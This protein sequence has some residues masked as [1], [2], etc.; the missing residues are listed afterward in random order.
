MPIAP[1]LDEALETPRLQALERMRLLDTPP[2]ESID[3]IIQLASQL[4]NVPIVLV[5]LVDKDRV[6]FKARHGIGV[7]EV[8]RAASICNQAILQDDVFV[9]PDALADPRF[10]DCPLVTGEPYVRFFAGCPLKAFSNHNIGTLCLIDLQ[11]RRFSGE[12]RELL[13]T[14]AQ[15]AQS[16]L[17]ELTRAIVDELTQVT[18]RGGFRQL[19]AQALAA[20]SQADRDSVLLVLNLNTLAMIKDHYGHE[21]GNT[22]LV[23]FA[24]S[25]RQSCGPSDIVG[26]LEDDR[27]AVFMPHAN[28]E[29]ARNM[30]RDLI[31]RIARLDAAGLLPMSLR[32]SIGLT[33]AKAAVD[34]DLDALLLKANAQL[35]ANQRRN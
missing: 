25:L 32:F 15:T 24:T 18:N 13:R 3:S 29:A 27:F 4:F 7:N 6:W 8:P 11:P 28:P 14:V 10:C 33:T 22:A 35:L 20:S 17:H 21:A 30:V 19:A 1:T 12:Q 26:R 16:R 2:D 23:Q 31:G 5:A 34:Q 9:V